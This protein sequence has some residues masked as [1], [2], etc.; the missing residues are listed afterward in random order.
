MTIA[1]KPKMT[2]KRKIQ[3]ITT[4]VMLFGAAWWI[5]N[6]THPQQFNSQ[7]DIDKCQKFK[8]DLA[9]PVPHDAEYQDNLNSYND[10]C[11]KLTGG[12]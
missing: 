9:L 11:A 4:G 1:N 10:M 7:Q 8:N 3:I 5:W 2:R 12:L 6:L